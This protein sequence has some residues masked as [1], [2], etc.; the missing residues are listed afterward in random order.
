MK[1]VIALILALA[2]T[3]AFAQV[4]IQPTDNPGNSLVTVRSASSESSHVL[5]AG[6]GNLYSVNATGATGYLMVFD[7]TSAPADGAVTPVICVPAGSSVSYLPG[8]P[9]YFSTGIV[10]VLSSTGCFTKTATNGFIFGLVK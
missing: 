10:A 4:Q 3:P 9:A 1:F 7:A 5:K 2:A 8:P 6:P